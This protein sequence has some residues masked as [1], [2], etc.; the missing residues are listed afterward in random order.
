M[1]LLL[2]LPTTFTKL[3]IYITVYIDLLCNKI[4]AKKMLLLVFF[5]IKQVEH[6]YTASEIKYK[7]M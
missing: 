4:V 1:S 2:L 6:V 3:L 7:C 5:D